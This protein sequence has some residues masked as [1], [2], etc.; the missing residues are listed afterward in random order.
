MVVYQEWTVMALAGWIGGVSHASS[1]YAVVLHME[2][3]K[4]DIYVTE[5]S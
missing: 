3:G 2:Q 1:G 5:P 4:G